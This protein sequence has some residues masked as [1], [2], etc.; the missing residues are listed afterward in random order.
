MPKSVGISFPGRLRTLA[1][2]CNMKAVEICCALATVVDNISYVYAIVANMMFI[3]MVL[4]EKATLLHA[5]FLNNTLNMNTVYNLHK[6]NIHIN[7]NEK[8][9]KKKRRAS[10]FSRYFGQSSR[11]SSGD[12]M[13]VRIVVTKWSK[14]VIE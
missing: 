7:Y 2:F 10:W 1:F 8:T 11:P 9:A 5:H 4:W 13:K 14:T 3:I 12:L 6:H